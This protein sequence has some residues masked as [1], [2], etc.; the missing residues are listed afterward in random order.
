MP[1]NHEE[2]NA[3]TGIRINPRSLLPRDKK[4]YHSLAGS[5]TTPPCSEGVEWYVLAE[6]ITMSVLQLD[7]LIGFYTEN[8][9]HIQDLNGRSISSKKE[10]HCDD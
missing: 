8:A 10:I 2:Q 7:Q 6:P 1:H 5:L 4:K 9:R 3:D